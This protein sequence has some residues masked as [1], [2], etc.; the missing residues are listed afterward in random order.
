MRRIS[1]IPVRNC[2]KHQVLQQAPS[3]EISNFRQRICKSRNKVCRCRDFRQRIDE[4]RKKACAMLKI[5]KP[6]LPILKCQTTDG[7][8]QKQGVSTAEVSGTRAADPEISDNIRARPETGCEHYRSARNQSY[9]CRKRWRRPRHPTNQLERSRI[10]PTSCRNCRTE[11]ATR[12][13]NSQ[14]PETRLTDPGADRGTSESR[15]A[16]KKSQQSRFQLQA[17]ME[18]SRK[19]RNGMGRP[20]KTQLAIRSSKV[21]E[22]QGLGVLVEMLSSGSSQGRGAQG[23][24]TP[25]P[26]EVEARSSSILFGKRCTRQLNHFSD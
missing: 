20:R 16:F 25:L 19:F 10:R 23:S 5:Q 14:S 17:R 13:G 2:S 24:S 26:I 9:R 12:R 11:V 3:T 6:E 21:S 7:R 8:V 4:L 22:F 1:P 18:A 15:R